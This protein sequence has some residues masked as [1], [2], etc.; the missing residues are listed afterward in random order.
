[1]PSATQE[2]RKRALELAAA[3]G[4]PVVT[5]PSADE[6]RE[7]RS[8]I[9]R[10]RDIEPEDVLGRQAVKLD[11]SAV[12]SLISGQTVFITGS[13]GSIGSELCRQIA[14]FGPSRLVLFELSEFALYQV[15]QELSELFPH[16]PLVRLVERLR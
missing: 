4:L 13:G 1:M 16:L 3:T 14:R 12:S 11:E 5:V 7:G 10:V 6:L 15:E 8:R 2:Q 9:D